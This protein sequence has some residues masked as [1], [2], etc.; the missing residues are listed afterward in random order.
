MS[1][2]FSTH[3]SITWKFVNVIGLLISK[4]FW[5]CHTGQTQAL[6]NLVHVVPDSCADRW[7]VA[8]GIVHTVI[9]RAK[10]A[11]GKLLSSRSSIRS[12][13]APWSLMAW[14]CHRWRSQLL[15][16][17]NVSCDDDSWAVG[18]GGCGGVNRAV[19]NRRTDVDIVWW[20]AGSHHKRGLVLRHLVL[21]A[22]P[23]T[24]KSS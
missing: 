10:R 20:V 24:W 4:L 15:V 16:V 1:L 11:L 8:V 7:A 19:T 5:L 6:P 21:E 14:R 13:I 9:H 17:V 3:S 18:C 12:S 23:R 2:V 22:Q